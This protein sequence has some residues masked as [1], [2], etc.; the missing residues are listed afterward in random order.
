MWY[1][2]GVMEHYLSRSAVLLFP[3][4]LLPF[5]TATTDSLRRGSK[6]NMTAEVHE[7]IGR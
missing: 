5:P 3:F 4:Y 1:N 6:D 7:G 2:R